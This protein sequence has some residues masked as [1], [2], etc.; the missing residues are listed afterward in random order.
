[1]RPRPMSTAGAAR[2]EAPTAPASAREQPERR[3][4]GTG[5]G[6]RRGR[7]T[8]ADGTHEHR[9][10]RPNGGT[11]GARERT[12]AARAAAERENWGRLVIMDSAGGR[13]SDP[14]GDR[15][16]LELQE[17]RLDVWRQILRFRYISVAALG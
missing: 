1:M 15:Y 11:H 4:S 17:H 13:G 6:A 5:G 9:W 10:R 16:A 12:R 3:L 14:S 7:P 2:T 8:E